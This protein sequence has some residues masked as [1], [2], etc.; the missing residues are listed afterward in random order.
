MTNIYIYISGNFEGYHSLTW[1]TDAAISRLLAG[2]QGKGSEQGVVPLLSLIPEQESFKLFV[3]TLIPSTMMVADVK[4]L[5]VIVLL[6]H[7]KDMLQDY[8]DNIITKRIDA[9][10]VALDIVERLRSWYI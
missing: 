3:V 7:Y 5:L 9:V 2:I 1:N 6:C 8:P 4:S 10:A